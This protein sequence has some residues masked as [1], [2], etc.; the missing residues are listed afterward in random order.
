[1]VGQV[2]ARRLGKA[3]DTADRRVR[4]SLPLPMQHSEK[5]AHTRFPA[6]LRAAFEVD[7]RRVEC[8]TRDVSL[9]GMFLDTTALPLPFG[10]ELTVTVTLPL[11]VEPAP[12]RCV[13]RWVTASGVGV[14]FLSLRAAETWA[15]N[16]L[17]VQSRGA[18]R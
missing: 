12:V 17:S 9:G 2:G 4:E 16:Q 10:A 18:P 13:V 15:I 3:D 11:L 14:S 1:M 7:G 5:R 6:R 8:R